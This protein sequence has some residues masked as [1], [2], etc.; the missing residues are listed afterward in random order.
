M[1]KPRKPGQPPR[2]P[3]GRGPKGFGDPSHPKRIAA[4]ARHIVWLNRRLNGERV[5]DIAAADGVAK[6][7]VSEAVRN[8][9]RECP[10]DAETMRALENERLDRD[11]REALAIIADAKKG[12]K[13]PGM[14]LQ[15]LD[16]RDR[17]SKGRRALNGLDEP[18]KAPV[19]KDGNTVPSFV[20]VPGQLPESVEEWVREYGNAAQRGADAE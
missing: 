2:R 6:G 15:A 16:R 14:I 3:K 10:E 9:I 11:E 19:D 8:L 17:I 13:K 4:R 1:R 12:K 18:A 7:T 20:V 5:I